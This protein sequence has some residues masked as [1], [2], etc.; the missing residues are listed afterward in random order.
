MSRI[1]TLYDFLKKIFDI[2]DMLTVGGIG[3]VGAGIWFIYWP[4]ALIIVGI[5]CASLG[6]MGSRLRRLHGNNS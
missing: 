1:K 5:F 3:M 6:V 4:A 2:E